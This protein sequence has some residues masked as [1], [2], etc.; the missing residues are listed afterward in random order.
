MCLLEGV[1]TETRI[2][3]VA[4]GVFCL[5]KGYAILRLDYADVQIVDDFS[6]LSYGLE[7]C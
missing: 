4:L 2:D 1:V 5:I 3:H 6:S 7:Q